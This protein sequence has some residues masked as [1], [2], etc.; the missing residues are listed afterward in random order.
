[1]TF[2][3]EEFAQRLAA[4]RARMAHQGLAALVVTDPAN[5]YYLTGYNAWSFYTPQMLYVPSEGDLILFA[6]AMD[7]QGAHRTSWPRA[8]SRRTSSALL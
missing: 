6:R 7:A 1:M 8:R 5:L 2:T 3:P 4:V